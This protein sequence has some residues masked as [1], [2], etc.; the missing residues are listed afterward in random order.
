ML[1]NNDILASLKKKNKYEFS[2]QK[3]IK[4]IYK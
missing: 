1:N 4:D 2:N 3:F